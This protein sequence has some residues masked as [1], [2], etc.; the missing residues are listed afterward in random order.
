MPAFDE[1]THQKIGMIL[2]RLDQAEEAR[3]AMAKDIND[4]KSA[5]QAL[6]NRNE[7]SDKFRGISVSFGKLMLGLLTFSGLIS[8]FN[9]VRAHVTW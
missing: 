6:V 7:V 2:A 5:V 8:A 3:S 1:E 9:W 4:L